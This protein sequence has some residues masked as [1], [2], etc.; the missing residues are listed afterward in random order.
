M[1]HTVPV[2]TLLPDSDGD[3]RKYPGWRLCKDF[4]VEVCDS[5]FQGHKFRAVAQ[6]GHLEGYGHTTTLAIDNLLIDLSFLA[7]HQEVKHH[8]QAREFVCP[9]TPLV[10]K[11]GTEL[12]NTVLNRNFRTTQSFF[13]DLSWSGLLGHWQACIWFMAGSDDTPRFLVATGPNAAEAVAELLKTLGEM[14]AAG[15]D[16][17]WPCCED[18]DWLS[19]RIEVQ[20]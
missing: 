15:R 18:Y 9:N 14:A 7:E 19:E 13:V 3:S 4:E 11:A 10:L 5:D 16:G 20:Q 6:D 8:R 17:C 12:P 2:G 1:K